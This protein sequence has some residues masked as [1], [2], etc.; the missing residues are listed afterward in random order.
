MWGPFF[1]HGVPLVNLKS[2]ER[3]GNIILTINDLALNSIPLI[4]CLFLTSFSTI[5]LHGYHDM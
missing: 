3:V 5:F 4:V 1:E 2:T